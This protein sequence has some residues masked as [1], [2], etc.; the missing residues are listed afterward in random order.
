MLAWWTLLYLESKNYPVKATNIWSIEVG[1][2]EYMKEDFN[3]LIC[4]ECDHI[5]LLITL[6]IDYTKRLSMKN[7]LDQID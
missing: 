6:T 4:C 7:L 3:L 1:S 5:N 2:N